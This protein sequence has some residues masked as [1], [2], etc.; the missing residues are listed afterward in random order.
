MPASNSRKFCA[1]R[2]ALSRLEREVELGGDGAVELCDQARRAS[3]Y[4]L[5][6]IAR[7]MALA[8]KYS[9]SMSRSMVSLMFGRWTFTTTS[10]EAPPGTLSMARCT[11]PMDAEAKRRLVER[12]VDLLEASLRARVRAAA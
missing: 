5:S 1:K 9:S 11:W 6:G 2:S 12:L 10:S 4:A 3:R 8:I 7:S